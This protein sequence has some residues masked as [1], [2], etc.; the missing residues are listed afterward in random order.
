M[1]EG[2]SA[3]F[4][5][6]TDPSLGLNLIQSLP[7]CADLVSYGISLKMQ[8]LIYKSS[9]TPHACVGVTVIW[10]IPIFALLISCFKSL[11]EYVDKRMKIWKSKCLKLLQNFIDY[12]LCERMSLFSFYN[13]GSCKL[14]Y[15]YLFLKLNYNWHINFRCTTMIQYS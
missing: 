12:T 14:I 5:S 13:T 9:A 3:A 8:H 11:Y 2:T 7:G 10:E 4:C 15:H 6:H 1:A